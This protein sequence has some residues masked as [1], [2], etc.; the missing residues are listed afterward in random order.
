MPYG[1]DKF[2]QFSIG[3]QIIVARNV[4]AIIPH[5]RVSAVKAKVCDVA[6]A[7]IIKFHQVFQIGIVC[8]APSGI[9]FA[10]SVIYLIVEF[11]EFILF[12][13]SIFLTLYY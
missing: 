10:E 8:Y 12:L 11:V 3:I 7:D 6:C 1:I 9:A 2:P 13:T 5:L 4:I